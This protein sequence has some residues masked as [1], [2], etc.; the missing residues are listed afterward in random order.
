MTEFVLIMR[1]TVVDTEDHPSLDQLQNSIRLWQEWYGWII[2]EHALA[3][4]LQCWDRVG[5]LVK[6]VDQVIDGPYKEGGETFHGLVIIRT[7][8]FDSA[9]NIARRCPILQL[10]GTVEIRREL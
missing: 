9:L 6:N 8:D 10:G 1:R 4:P 2:M 5:R 7:A 3:R